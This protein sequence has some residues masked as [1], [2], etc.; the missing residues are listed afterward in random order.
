MAKMS[1]HFHSYRIEAENEAFYVEAMYEVL[2]EYT[3]QEIN[4]AFN[5]LVKEGREFAPN[6]GQIAKRIED[7]REKVKGED[8]TPA[9]AWALARKAICNSGYHAEEEFSKLPPKAQAFFGSASA[10]HD[11]SQGSISEIDTVIQSNFLKA[12]RETREENRIVNA[13]P[14]DVRARIPLQAPTSH[15]ERV[16]NENMNNLPLKD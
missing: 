14:D 9:Q 6:A 2:A 16:Q 1:C 8:L 3:P 12:Y 11:L 15:L 5:S 13:L 4:I 10:L 7:I